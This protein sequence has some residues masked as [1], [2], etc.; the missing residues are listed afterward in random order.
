LS[1]LINGV[2]PPVNGQD[3]LISLKIGLAALKSIKEDRP[4]R[5]DEI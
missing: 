3:G 1:C 4:V 5:I 2:S